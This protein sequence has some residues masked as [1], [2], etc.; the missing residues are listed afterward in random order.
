MTDSCG[1]QIIKTANTSS[2]KCKGRESCIYPKGT[3]ST[4]K[5]L[6][7]HPIVKSG[8]LKKK[9][10][11]AMAVKKRQGEIKSSCWGSNN[12]KQHKTN[13]IPCYSNGKYMSLISDANK[14]G[15]N[16]D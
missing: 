5:A 11:C 7:H 9:V 6:Y 4:L 2:C 12:G 10:I 8:E 13:E 1:S 3:Y 16:L 14:T 15:K